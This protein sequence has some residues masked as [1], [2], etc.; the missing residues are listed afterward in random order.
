MDIF[1]L[2]WVA[3]SGTALQT[4]LTTSSEVSTTPILL[5]L[6]YQLKLVKEK[7]KALEQKLLGKK[8]PEVQEEADQEPLENQNLEE[9]ERE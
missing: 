8:N 3:D 1:N 4:I 9:N 2:L 6:I 7:V 5:W